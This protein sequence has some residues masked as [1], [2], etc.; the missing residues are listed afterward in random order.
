MRHVNMAVV[1][2]TM[3]AFAATVMG[4]MRAVMAATTREVTMHHV[5]D[6]VVAMMLM[7]TGIAGPSGYTQCQQSSS[8]CE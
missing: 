6:G 7:A 5:S 4:V 2:M 1:M 8:N 3:A